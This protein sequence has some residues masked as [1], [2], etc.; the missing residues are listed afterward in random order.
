MTRGFAEVRRERVQIVAEIVRSGGDR[1]ADVVAEEILS[2][3][4][5]KAD[6]AFATLG[7]IRL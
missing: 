6:P 2:A 5:G 3:V 4:D 1:C 7:R